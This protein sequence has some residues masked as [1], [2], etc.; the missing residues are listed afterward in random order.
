[1]TNEELK[2]HSCFNLIQEIRNRLSQEDAKT[3]LQPDDLEFFLNGLSYFESGIESSDIVLVNIQILNSCNSYLSNLKNDLNNFLAN[4]NYGH[5]NNAKSHIYSIIQLVNQLPLLIPS[6]KSLNEIINNF[7]S[8]IDTEQSIIQNK[9]SSLQ[10]KISDIN[11]KIT[12]IQQTVSQQ[13]NQVNQLTTNYTKQFEEQKQKFN[14]GI[15][16]TSKQYKSKCDNLIEEISKNLEEARKLVNV[17]GNIGVSG[18][19]QK[20]AEYHKKQA[21]LWRWI[22]IGFMVVSVVYL[23]ITVFTISKYDW[24]ISLLR[25]LSTALFIYPAQY[26]A[27]QSNKHRE[28]EFFNK[29]M[30]LDLA[31]INP[32]IE[33]FDEKKKQDIKEKLVDKYFTN[34]V[35]QKS[36]TEIPVPIFEKIFDQI[37]NLLTIIKK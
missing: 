11:N 12:Q 4:K 10:Q 15:E 28:Q 31:A 6:K 5:I 7:K 32:F 18:D 1:M 25:I 27:S 23:G 9:I 29:K 20:T 2:N 36:E 17:I 22:A 34:Y 19:Y 16:E 30:E 14:Q 8:R 24:H 21:N 33:L 37:K 35:A 13:Q 3:L 26:A